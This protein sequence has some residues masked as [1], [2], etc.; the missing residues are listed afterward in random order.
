MTSTQT[1]SIS[2]EAMNGGGGTEAMDLSVDYIF[3]AVSRTGDAY[4]VNL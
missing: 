4:N 1:Y 3:T 2:I